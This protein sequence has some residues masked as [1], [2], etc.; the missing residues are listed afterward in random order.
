M[1]GDKIKYVEVTYKYKLYETYLVFVDING[2][3]ID[4]PFIKLT[5]DGRLIIMKGYAWD[6][7]SGPTYDSK[8]TLRTS[9]VHDALYQLIREGF[10]PLRYRKHADRLLKD[11][12]IEDGMSSIRARI[13]EFAVNNFA[14]GTIKSDIKVLSAPR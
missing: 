12:G 14:A 1:K 10:L 4:T 13:W 9:L 3:C 7:P 11:F 2:L 6:G 5:A 8:N